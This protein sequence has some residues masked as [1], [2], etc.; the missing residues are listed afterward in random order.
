MS[1][2]IAIRVEHLSKCYHIF[3]KPVHRLYRMLQRGNKRHGREF[4]AVEDVSFE[5][6]RGETVGIIGRNGAGK[7][8]LLQMVCGTLNQT[9]GTVI[10]NG[11]IAAL[12]EL[13]AGFN[14]EFTGRE[15][16]YL[17]ASLY[18]LS[19]AEVT[20]RFDA[21]AAF[22]D[23]GDFI[24]QPVKTYSS[25]MFVRLAFAVIAHVDAD[26]LVVDEALSVGDAYFQQ[27]CM[28]FLNEFQRRGGT[29]LFVS[30]DMGTV[31]ALC[32]SAILLRRGSDG[33]YLCDAGTAKDISTIYLREMY[34]DRIEL[35]SIDAVPVVDEPSPKSTPDADN[36]VDGPMAFLAKSPPTRFHASSFRSD[37]EGFGALGGIIT[38]AWFRGINGET[39]TEFTSADQVTLVVRAHTYKAM[40]YPAIGFM[41]KDRKGQYVLTES[42]DSYLRAQSITAPADTDIEAE[43]SMRMP[44]L[45][46]GE[47]TLDVAFAEGPGLDHVQHHW[48]HDV[49]IINVINN[50]V[51]HGIAGAPSLSVRLVVGNAGTG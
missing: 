5:I 50:H 19:T 18:G 49:M 47:Y 13:G 37:T 1:S 30:H 32:A 24:E 31:N 14:P 33:R 2:D 17:A 22:A 48:L 42:T 15:N 38:G 6:H 46:R 16:V 27:K 7:S 51:V 8:T 36:I 25:G 40:T 41:V 10:V 3:D 34:A 35:S 28:R 11:K 43:F 39:L 12:L 21:I 45:V 20:K 29:L 9:T 4:W 23:I 26:I 44:N